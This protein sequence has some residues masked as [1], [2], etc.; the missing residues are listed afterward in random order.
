MHRHEV[1]NALS[2]GQYRSYLEIGVDG[3]FTFNQVDIPFK[4]GVDPHFKL[5]ESELFGR[6]YNMVSDTYFASHDTT[7]D[8]VFIDGLHTYG[9]S[10]Q[11]FINAWQ[12]RN[13]SGIVILD[14]CDPADEL[15]ALPDLEECL[16]RRRAAGRPDDHTW[17]GDVYRTVLWLHDHTDYA[18]AYVR[19]SLGMVVVW[20]ETQTRG[21]LFSNEGAIAECDFATFKSLTLPQLS[22]REIAARI[23]RPRAKPGNS[24]LDRLIHRLNPA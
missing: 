21:K 7:F 1:I 4:T 11:D 22:V 12:R 20:P 9:Q 6:T 23:P 24:L 16:R 18:F 10:K 5:P 13:D 19:E 17:M 8:C 15:A 2:N 14:D 3:G